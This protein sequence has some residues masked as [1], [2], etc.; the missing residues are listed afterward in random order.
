[1]LRSRSRSKADS[2]STYGPGGAS[3]LGAATARGVSDPRRPRSTRAPYD[4]GPQH[5]LSEERQRERMHVTAGEE[6]LATLAASGLSVE[7]HGD[8]ALRRDLDVV[9][10]GCEPEPAHGVLLGAPRCRSASAQVL[11]LPIFLLTQPPLQ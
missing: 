10:P 8:G 3:L 11:A 9:A 4:G 2:S 1:M 6:G 5:T 7:R